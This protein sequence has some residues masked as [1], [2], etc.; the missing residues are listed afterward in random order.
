[1][2]AQSR[3]DF[4]STEARQSVSHQTEP[5]RGLLCTRCD[6]PTGSSAAEEGNEIAPFQGLPPAEDSPCESEAARTGAEK[7]KMENGSVKVPAR[8]PIEP[9]MTIS[10]LAPSALT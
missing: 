5:D 8:N 9:D 3:S 2:N 4:R 6:R 7:L 10:N 1:M